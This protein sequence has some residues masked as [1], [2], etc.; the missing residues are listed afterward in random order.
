ML[1]GRKTHA[2]TPFARVALAPSRDRTVHLYVPATDLAY[3]EEATSKWRI[4]PIGYT[5]IVGRHALDPNA[6]RTDFR[7]V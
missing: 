3:Y 6:L 4:E 2:F 5:A 1:T 7:G